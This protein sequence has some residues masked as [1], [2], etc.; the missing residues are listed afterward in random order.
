[1]YIHIRVCV[2]RMYICI[3]MCVHAMPFDTYI[4]DDYVCTCIYTHAH[5]QTHTHTL[6][7]THTNIDSDLAYILQARRRVYVHFKIIHIF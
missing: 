4:V 2:L 3:H 7:H 1:M 5:T 6:I